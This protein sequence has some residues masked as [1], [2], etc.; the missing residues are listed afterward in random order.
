MRGENGHTLVKVDLW[1]DTLRRAGGAVT[2]S[3][4]LCRRGRVHHLQLR[5]V[6]VG[7]RRRRREDVEQRRR[8]LLQRQRLEPR[9]VDRCAL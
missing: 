3:G 9:A 7:E 6:E 2:E 1:G 4:G 8:E 5:E